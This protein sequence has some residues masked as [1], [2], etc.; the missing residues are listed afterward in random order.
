MVTRAIMVYPQPVYNDYF[1]LEQLDY[2]RKY[3]PETLTIAANGVI[4][5]M[6]SELYLPGS[7]GSDG[8]VVKYSGLS[9]KGSLVLLKGLRPKQ[10][11]QT[12]NIT[13]INMTQKDEGLVERLKK[14][15]IDAVRK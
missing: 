10:D 14:A 5:F 7:S 11:W 4:R 6:K 3:T 2:N 9:G 1:S 12:A 8:S 15:A 13:V